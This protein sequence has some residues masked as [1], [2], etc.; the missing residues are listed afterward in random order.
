MEC[1]GPGLFVS[2]HPLFCICIVLQVPLPLSARCEEQQHGIPMACVHAL[3]VCGGASSVHAQRSC[4]Y[5]WCTEQEGCLTA[6][7]PACGNACSEDGPSARP[8]LRGLIFLPTPARAG[9]SRP[10]QRLPAAHL[11]GRIARHGRLGCAGHQ[12]GEESGLG[13]GRHASCRQP[14]CAQRNSALSVRATTH[15]TARPC[16]CIHVVALLSTGPSAPSGGASLDFA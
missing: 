2:L 13:L 10:Q 8:P 14:H 12:G 9:G 15:D 3:A 5:W 7:L 16:I 11:L 1:Y 6:C 4:C